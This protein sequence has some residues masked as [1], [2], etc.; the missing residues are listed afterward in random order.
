MRVALAQI[1]HRVVMLVL[2]GYWKVFF[3]A[4]QGISRRQEYRADEL[5]CHIGGS[6]SLV[7]GL[8]KIHGAGAAFPAYW[9]FEVLPL[10][11]IGRRPSIAE[12]FGLFVSA[13]EVSS[14]IEKTVTEELAQTKMQIYDSHPPLRDRIAA[15]QRVPIA[16]QKQSSEAATSLFGDLLAEEAR[17]FAM[18]SSES[19]IANL[20]P[21]A[22][23]ELPAILPRIWAEFLANH[24]EFLG[25]VTADSMPDIIPRLGE[26][27]SKMPDPKGMLL[28]PEQRTARAT[29]L[30]GVALA[31]AIVD[32]GWVLHMKP[33]EHYY[34]CGSERISARRLMND[35]VSKKMAKDE[36]VQRCQKLN[37]AGVR[38]SGLV[39][40]LKEQHRQSGLLA[41]GPRN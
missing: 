37:I 11:N 25:D 26:I 14:Q 13:P 1:V 33:G 32:A 18:S 9:N 10:L 28:T 40:S 24:S 6:R 36:W 21:V 22:W 4:T 41:R 7:S 39:D 19:K 31:L 15:A 16:P 27:G 35:L 8:R 38:L 2:H 17:I 29:E 3:R 30:F 34:E 12:G 20:E 23:D 5:A